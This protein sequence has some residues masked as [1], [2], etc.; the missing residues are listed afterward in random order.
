MI[1]LADP[2]GKTHA[3]ATLTFG[4]GIYDRKATCHAC[5]DQ[6]LIPAFSTNGHLIDE[7]DCPCCATLTDW[8]RP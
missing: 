1:T 7:I 8:S 4:T 2:L 3:T 6:G 5:N